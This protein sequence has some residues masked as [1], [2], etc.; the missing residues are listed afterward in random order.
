MKILITIGSFFPAQKGGP[1][2]SVFNLA[3]V[4]SNNTDN[5]QVVCLFDS[6]NNKLKKKFDIKEN[7]ITVISNLKVIYFKYYF[8]RLF[9]PQYIWWLIKNIKNYQ[10]IYVNSI[11]FY[12]SFLVIFISGLSRKKLIISPR[13]ELEPNAIK[14]KYILKKIYLAIIFKFISK[15]NTTILVTSKEEIKKSKKFLPP[16]IKYSIIENF[17]DLD[18]SD[19]V[20]I[21]NNKNRKNLIYLGRI[22]PKKN[23]EEL[24][25]AYSLL[26][27]E[28]KNYHKLILIGTGK[29][30]YEEKLINLISELNLIDYVEFLGH[31]V[32]NEKSKILSSSKLLVLPSHTENFG[33]VILEAY[34]CFLPCVCSSN[35]PWKILDD[36][37][38]GFTYQYGHKELSN[39]INKILNWDDKTYYEICEK[40]R[41][42]IVDNYSTKNKDNKI[43]NFLRQIEKY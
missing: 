31:K 27:D 26:N 41:Q 12:I 34:S 36:L 33:N 35:T 7:S 8:Y 1:D 21:Q 29:L 6:I 16:N 13:G 23:I 20:N 4:I 43:K 17:I 24:I 42:Y 37:N 39:K 9:S 18:S 19:Y 22:H 40:G 3:K 2:N 5:V 10:I 14:Y 30:N 38:I 11:F 15:K 32:G 25:L 28:I